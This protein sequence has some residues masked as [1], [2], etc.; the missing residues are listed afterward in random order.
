MTL[1]KN[2]QAEFIADMVDR[3]EITLRDDGRPVGSS[4]ES[5]ANVLLAIR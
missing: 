5:G 2:A 4:V 1:P 3:T